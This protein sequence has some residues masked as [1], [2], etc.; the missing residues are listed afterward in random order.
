[1]RFTSALSALLLVTFPALVHAADEKSECVDA[2]D[3]GQ[4]ARAAGHMKDARAKFLMCAAEAC[5]SVVRKD[6]SQWLKETEEN[7][8]SFVPVASRPD[9]SDVADVRVYVDGAELLQRLDGKAI[10]IDPGMHEFRFEADG[11]KSRVQMN[12]LLAQGEKNRRI[13]AK[14][15]SGGAVRLDDSVRYERTRGPIP[16]TAYVL[17]GVGV[18]GLSSFAYF[19]FSG[20]NDKDALDKE[21]CAPTCAQSRVDDAHTKFI[22]ADV[23][24]GVSLAAITASA[25]ITL[26]RPWKETAVAKAP[27]SLPVFVSAAPQGGSI[28]FRSSF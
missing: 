25:I 2:A 19:G 4:D 24:L 22:I 9:G 17:A 14:F 10:A 27:P 5:P 12:V 13:V 16:A 26:T 18:L 6:C 28:G 7:L 20:L 8:P 21:K 11:G 3:R 15:S 1:M 23:S